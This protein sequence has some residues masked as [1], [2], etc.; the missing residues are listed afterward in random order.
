MNNE[1]RYCISEQRKS[2]TVD[3]VNGRRRYTEWT[4]LYN[5]GD[6]ETVLRWVDL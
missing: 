3:T 2:W 5:D 6:V 4:Y 1:P